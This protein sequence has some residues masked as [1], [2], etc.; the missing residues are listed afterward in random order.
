ME[1]FD[2][3]FEVKK[4]TDEGTFRGFASTFGNRDLAGDVIRRG[5]FK[6]SIA[7]PSRIKL[8][9]SHDPA[10][11]IGVWKSL[12]ETDKGLLAVGQLALGVRRGAE[13]LELMR[14]GAVDALS[15]GF[16]VPK[17]GSQFENETRILTKIELLEISV[18]GIPANPQARIT[19]ARAAFLRGGVADPVSFERLL[20]ERMR[21]DGI[22][23]RQVKALLSDGYRGLAPEAAE[24]ADLTDLLASIERATRA[25][26]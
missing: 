16:R 9:W 19:E 14:M 23:R 5:A 17:N 25:L 1:T 6:A 4:L 26:Q 18:V 2:A 11:I 3:P 10:Q 22:S 13:T 21:D 7:S 20:Y 15:I 24:A 12:E 8:L